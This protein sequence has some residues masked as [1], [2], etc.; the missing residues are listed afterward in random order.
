MPKHKVASV[1]NRTEWAI[2]LVSKS[3]T[4]KHFRVSFLNEDNENEKFYGDMTGEND[5][6]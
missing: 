5:I 3:L 2:Y 4:M 6:T 1:I